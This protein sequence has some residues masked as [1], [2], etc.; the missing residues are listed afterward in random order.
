MNDEECGY[1]DRNSTCLANVC[2]CKDGFKKK[3]LTCVPIISGK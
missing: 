3:G 2:E 1:G